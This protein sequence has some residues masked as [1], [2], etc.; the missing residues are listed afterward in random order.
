MS[1]H[2]F[3]EVYDDLDIDLKTLGCVMLKTETPDTSFIRD[4]DLYYS[5]DPK[6][7]WINGRVPNSHIT[8]KYGLMP[9]V[10]REHVDAVIKDMPIPDYLV[11]TGIT[12]FASP[13][14]DEPYEC[15][16][17][18]IALT[19]PLAALHN[20]LNYLPHINTFPEYKPHITLAYVRKGWYASL[21]GT[22]R[23]GYKRLYTTHL[24]YGRMK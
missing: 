2:D 13:Y 15:I 14:P 11:P 21:T 10:R 5:S 17:L 23:A 18:P 8:L 22:P 6:L 20:H 3:Q 24:D 19:P 4:E 1:A 9:Q 7:F 16:V 12:M